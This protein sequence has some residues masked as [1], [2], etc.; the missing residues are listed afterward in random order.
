MLIGARTVKT[1]LAVATTL[2]ICNVFSIE[3]ASFAAI[4]A[5]VNMQ[6]SVSKSI[7]NAWEQIGVHLLA[8]VFSLIMGLLFGTNP[9]FIGTTVVFLIIFCN[10]I[11]WPNGIVMGIVSIIFILDSPRETF[12]IHALSRSLS[13]FVGLGVALLINRILA[14]PRYKSKFMSTLNDL[15]QLTS[16]YFLE[17]LNTFIHAGNFTYY[18]RPDPQEQQN[19]LDE[20]TNLYEHARE[21]MTM[22][23]HP[24]FIERLLEICRGFI[25]RGES[26]NQMTAQRVT[27]RRESYSP[28]ELQEITAEFKEILDILSLGYE[29]L[30]GLIDSLSSGVT[31]KKGSGS[32]TED[33]GYWESF[34]RAID[35]WN[36]KVCGVFYLRALM[37]VSVV[38]TELRWANRRTINLLNMINK[39]SEKKLKK[40]V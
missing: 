37:E 24:P 2:F 39:Q 14:P 3:P 8:I 12:L 28:E 35:D 33:I 26:I 13:I 40:S 31:E 10:W 16:K 9:I 23:D 38:A 22:D 1:G 6:P 32:Y 36:R 21:E 18:Q 20:V 27:R 30:A 7:N 5:V 4:T 19:L 34:D 17:S 25:E 11:G 29:K 15:V